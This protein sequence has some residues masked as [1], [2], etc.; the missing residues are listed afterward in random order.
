MGTE[1][2]LSSDLAAVSLGKINQGQVRMMFQSLFNKPY[3][4]FLQRFLIQ[5]CTS[6][7]TVSNTSSGQG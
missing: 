1:Q 3:V 6:A 4:S 7:S 2:S 5:S